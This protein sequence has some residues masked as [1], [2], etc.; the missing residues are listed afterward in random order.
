MQCGTGLSNQIYTWDMA[1]RPYEKENNAINLRM[2]F[3]TFRIVNR[4][5]SVSQF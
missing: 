2:N 4:D 1:P 3:V 5:A